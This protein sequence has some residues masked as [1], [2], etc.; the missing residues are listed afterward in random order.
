MGND[1]GIVNHGRSGGF[2]VERNGPNNV[3][4]RL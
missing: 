4:L 3:V 1:L 2:E